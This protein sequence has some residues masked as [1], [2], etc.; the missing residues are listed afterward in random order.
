MSTEPTFPFGQPTVW[1]PNPRWIAESNLQDFM[2]R[3]GIDDYDALHA[4]ARSIGGSSRSAENWS[5]DA[6]RSI[7][8]APTC[9]CRDGRPIR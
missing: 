6:R 4:R 5:L 3:H 2:N 9:C 8:S 1:Q 7:S